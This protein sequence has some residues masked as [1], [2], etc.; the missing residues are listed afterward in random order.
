MLFEA[1]A[2][3]DNV[4]RGLVARVGEEV[5]TTAAAL[6]KR[7]ELQETDVE[8]VLGGSVFRGRGSLLLETVRT[9]IRQS[10]PRARVVL[11]EFH[12]VVG[13]VLQALRNLGI[14]VDDRIRGNLRA[15]LPAE[16]LEPR[17]ET[18]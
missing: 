10:A 13:A 12:P 14:D 15:S 3:G 17:A 18:G 11:P 5:G 2:A 7:L 16:L 8:V 9:T 6:I 1:A 4:A